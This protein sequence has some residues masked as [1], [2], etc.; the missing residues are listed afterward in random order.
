MRVIDKIETT[1]WLSEIGLLDQ[2]GLLCL[3]SYPNVVRIKIPADS[4]KKTALSK[5]IGSFFDVDSESLLWIDE[6]GIW[7]SCEDW[8]LFEGFRRS[9]GESSKLYEK[10]GHIF[11]RND[12]GVVKSLLAMVLY[13]YW[14]AILVSKDKSLI[15]RISHD[16]HIVVYA[17]KRD[18]L[19]DVEKIL[20][21]FK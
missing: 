9:I 1:T 5:E 13:F 11:C 20:N 16:E 19:Y 6:F 14:G 17:I 2:S 10:P 18:N 8:N 15:V 12:L 7:P 21:E 3:S 4:G